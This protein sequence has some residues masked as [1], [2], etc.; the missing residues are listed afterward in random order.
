MTI[1]WSST[2]TG[3]STNWRV[4]E[5]LK[6]S[7]FFG[8][9]MH[10]VCLRTFGRLE[11]RFQRPWFRILHSVEEDNYSPSDSISFPCC[12]CIKI[13]TNKHV[14][15]MI[16]DVFGKHT[17]CHCSTIWTNSIITDFRVIH[18]MKLEGLQFHWF[19][20]CPWVLMMLSWLRNMQRWVHE[21][22]STTQFP[23][24]A[25]C[26]LNRSSGNLKWNLTII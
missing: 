4:S 1:D 24:H 12:Q 14:S 18:K 8:W 20:I 21:L 15:V 7:A 9:F 26:F 17:F 25:N 2:V 5:W 11:I 6:W 22:I 19:N 10:V 13:S 16:T 23:K 3:I